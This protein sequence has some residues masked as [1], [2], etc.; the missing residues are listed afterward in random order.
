MSYR[1]C[2]EACI[3]KFLSC[4]A[5]AFLTAASMTVVS[6][7]SPV[8]L[9]YGPMKMTTTKTEGTL[10]F[11]DSPEYAAEEG[12]LGEGTIS[13]EG[14]IYYYHVNSLY[15]G[16]HLVVYGTSDHTAAV[17][18]TDTVRGDPSRGY[19]DTGR[20]LSFRDAVGLGDRKAKD[21]V[22]PP[23]RRTILFEDNPDGI[24]LDDLV[25]GFVDVETKGPVRF[26]TAIIKNGGDLEGRLQTLPVLEADSHEMRGTFP[27]EI[28]MTNDTVW[29]T[30]H[31]GPADIKLGDGDRDPSYKGMDEL[32]GV[33]REN[34]GNF[35]M[36]YIITVRTAGTRD[37][38]MYINPMGGAF[39]ATFF[40]RQD[41]IPR[42]YRT[43]EKDRWFGNDDYEA[44]MPVGTWRAG[45]NLTIDITIPGAAYLPVR[46][47]LVPRES[48]GAER[49]EEAK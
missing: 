17:T 45:R 33:V 48:N 10:V 16:A 25:S 2:K 39:L 28:Y 13:G 23:K 32:S 35:G 1:A 22:L 27:Q 29:N 34:T 14:R 7:S 31:D 36:E 3:I 11:S 4:I 47:L 40:V 42:I 21:K 20:T 8:D 6:A 5:A 30:D 19:L 44:W 41:G 38:D 46:F 49:K 24:A 15:P 9:D 26:G 43:D 18:V 37:F 12:I